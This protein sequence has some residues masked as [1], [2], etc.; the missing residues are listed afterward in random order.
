MGEVKEET[1]GAAFLFVPFVTTK[2]SPVICIQPEVAVYGWE[3]IEEATSNMPHQR[4]CGYYFLNYK[5]TSAEKHHRAMRTFRY[6]L[7][8]GRFQMLHLATSDIRQEEKEIDFASSFMDSTE[9]NPE[10][11]V[12]LLYTRQTGRWLGICPTLLLRGSGRKW[13]TSSL[14]GSNRFFTEQWDTVTQKS[15]ALFTDFIEGY[16][17]Q[18]NA[19]ILRKGPYTYTS[20]EMHHL[21]TDFTFTC[22][23]PQQAETLLKM[24]YPSPATSGIPTLQAHDFIRLHEHHQRLYYGGYVGPLNLQGETCCYLNTNCMH[25]MAAGRILHFSGN[26]VLS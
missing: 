12:Y 17:Q 5:E 18:M 7:D 4:A 6:Q 16:L 13:H 2:A 23:R 14:M 1:T 21:C 26:M 11:M 20:G 24:F 19:Q 25:Q 15:Q 8:R 9:K 22:Q 10:A 3:L